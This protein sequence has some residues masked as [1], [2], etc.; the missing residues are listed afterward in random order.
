MDRQLTVRID[1]F[2]L[3]WLVLHSE[4]ADWNAGV[5]D[6][7]EVLVRK[8]TKR[9]AQASMADL[10][11]RKNPD[12]IRTGETKAGI[13]WPDVTDIGDVKAQQLEIGELQFLAYD[14]GCSLNLSSLM[15]GR[16]GE[17]IPGDE[18]QCPA[19]RLATGLD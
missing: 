17:G 10:E 12:H 2:G 6:A 11:M 19:I 1:Q 5:I 7:L 14:Y 15:R 4:M 18:N 9:T 13:N 16:S 8:G 3:N